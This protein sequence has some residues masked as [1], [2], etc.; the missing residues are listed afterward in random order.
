MLGEMGKELEMDWKIVFKNLPKKCP[1]SPI[2]WNRG[3]LE[4]RLS[5]HGHY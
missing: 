4:T 5:K 2:S 1:S 3:R